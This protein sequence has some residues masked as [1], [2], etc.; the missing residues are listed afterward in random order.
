MQKH[1]LTRLRTPPYTQLLCGPWPE[2]INGAAP[3]SRVARS[4]RRAG[5]VR[6]PACVLSLSGC[7]RRTCLFKGTA[8]LP[9]PVLVCYR[10][11]SALNSWNFWLHHVKVPAPGTVN[12]NGWHLK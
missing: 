1:I 10:P 3:S 5:L 11:F 6:A 4:P 7:T 9:N 8:K 12:F 2:H